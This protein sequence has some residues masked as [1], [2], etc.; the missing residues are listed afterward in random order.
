MAGSAQ[1]LLAQGGAGKKKEAKKIGS[2]EAFSNTKKQNFYFFLEIYISFNKLA[3]S[4][5]S[6]LTA[7]K[8][9]ISAGKKLKKEES[10]EASSGRKMMMMM[11]MMR[12]MMMM[13]IMFFNIQERRAGPKTK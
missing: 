12:R 13:M 11:L 5:R 3:K 8:S 7:F 9:K 6:G 1:S 10:E 4:S 2:G